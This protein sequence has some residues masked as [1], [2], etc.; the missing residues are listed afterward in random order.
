MEMML[1]AR[2]K[3]KM[4]RVWS[5]GAMGNE[6]DRVEKRRRSCLSQ[7]WKMKKEEY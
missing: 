5:L 3:R 2:Y 6:E 4:G 7:D 1:H